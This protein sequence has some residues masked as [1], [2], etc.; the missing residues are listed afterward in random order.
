MPLRLATGWREYSSRVRISVSRAALLF[1]LGLALQPEALA[2]VLV[3][4]LVREARSGLP[5]SAAHV[6]AESGQAGTITNREG[7]FELT[8]QALPQVILVRHVGYQT[9]RVALGPNDSRDLMVDLEA[10]VYMLDELLVTGEDFADNVMRKAVQ[11]KAARRAELARLQMRGYTRITLESRAQIVLVSEAVFDS[12]RDR[13]R[14]SRDVIRSRR[15]TAGFYRDLGLDHTVVDLSEDYVRIQSLRFI[16]PTHPDALKHYHF[17]F[18]GHRRMSEGFVYDIYVAP[19]TSL[20]ATFTGRVSI[21]DSTYAL[22]AAELRPARHVQWNPPVS[23]W[24][25]FYRQQFLGVDSLWLPL[26]LRVEGRI[27]YGRDPVQADLQQVSQLSDHR[28][29]ESIPEALFAVQERTLVDSASVF[30][31]D[32]FLLGRGF[33]ALTP[34]EAEAR[35]TLQWQDLTLRMALPPVGKPRRP[36]LPWDEPQ[37][38]WP[39]IRG[40]EPWLGF[41]RVDGFL[42][43]AGRTLEITRS[44]KVRV[45]AA[46]PTREERTRYEVQAI[47]RWGR[48]FA[49]D[50]SYKHGAAPQWKSPIVT[51]AFSSLHTLLGG[52]DYFDYLYARQVRLRAGYAFRR[53]RLS[54]AGHREWFKSLE[55]VQARS[56]PFRR[57]LRPNPTAPDREL[58]SASLAVSAGDS[59]MP[60]RFGPVRGIGVD[61]ERGAFFGEEGDRAF[62]RVAARVD[63]HARTFFRHRPIPHRLSVRLFGAAASGA[64]PAVRRSALD[65]APGPVS[66]FGMLRGMG[67]GSYVGGRVLGLFW[68]HDF[69][70]S[71]FELLGLRQLVDR[72]TGVRIAGGHAVA[73]EAHHELTLSLAE[74]WGSPVRLDLT[75]RLDRPG[76]FLGLGIS[77]LP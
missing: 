40:Q 62:L 49:S 33:V 11:R 22:V 72:R 71:L 66:S 54:L 50:V 46:Q 20:E 13:I 57:A 36:L 56:W 69:Q 74:I 70:T 30:R 38:S 9:Q 3:R 59:H 75:Y 47:R 23:R 17:T 58:L 65:G 18:A 63:G 10:A 2:Q 61:I 64:L 41:N 7:R 76:L 4:G 34:A 26:S 5:L 44:T 51:P 21:M 14:G 6:V 67:A 1:L 68:E 12:Y 45:R 16:G 32:L 29:N 77:R 55:T 43:G 24:D 53:I 15:E 39:S 42:L 19:K 35:E 25:V 8:L 73:G 31:D 27:A 48:G 37:F 60:F 52:R 28:L